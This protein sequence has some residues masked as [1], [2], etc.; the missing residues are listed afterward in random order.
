VNSFKETLSLNT[1]VDRASFSI[2]N[3]VANSMIDRFQTRNIQTRVCVAGQLDYTSPNGA[4]NTVQFSTIVILESPGWGAPM[5]PSYVYDVFLEP[6]KKGYTQRKSISQA[7]K[8][9]EVDHFLLRIATSRSANFLFSMDILDSGGKI[10]WKGTFD[11]AVLVPRLG[12]ALA[13]RR[14]AR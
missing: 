4:N 10:A 2:T 11:M 13:L 3:Y 14:I 7:I 12:A 9:G 8:P 6:G 1:F 5:P